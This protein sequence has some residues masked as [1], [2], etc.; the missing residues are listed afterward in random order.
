[1]L[2]ADCPVLLCSPHDRDGQDHAPAGADP[3]AQGHHHDRPAQVA[4]VLERQV[5]QME[6]RPPTGASLRRRTPIGPGFETGFGRAVVND[7]G[8][9]G[10]GPDRS[11][12]EGIDGQSS[13]AWPAQE[14]GKRPEAFLGSLFE[15]KASLTLDTR[16]KKAGM[17]ETLRGLPCTLTCAAAQL[18]QDLRLSRQAKTRRR[19][20]RPARIREETEEAGNRPNLECM[21]RGAGKQAR[22]EER[23]GVGAWGVA[24]EG[25]DDRRCACFQEA[26]HW[27]EAS[28]EDGLRQDE[29]WPMVA[30]WP[31]KCLTRA[32]GPSRADQ[33]RPRAIASCVAEE[34]REGPAG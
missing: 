23:E 17:G 3:V 9:V 33:R 34:N 15:G 24:L 12:G 16:G 19:R 22:L 21:G 2:L 30:G 31:G 13:R 29:S 27:R 5:L 1:M 18:N 11:E 28:W 14:R 4:L 25:Y 10:T 26:R 6:R 20:H 32:T 8:H 7:D